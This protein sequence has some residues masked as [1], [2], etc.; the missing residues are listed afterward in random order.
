MKP[1]V[2]FTKK[3]EKLELLFRLVESGLVGKK[4]AIKIHFGEKGNVTYLSPKYVKTVF[5]RLKD[6]GYKPT[7]IES[8]VLYQGERTFAKSHIALAKSHGYNFGPIDIYD[9]RG[10]KDNWSVLIKG[11]HFKQVKLVKNLQRYDSLV[12]FSHFK[13]HVRAGFG[14]A[15]KNLGMGLASRAGKLAMHVNLAPEIDPERCIACGK[16]IRSCP[17]QAISLKGNKAFIDKK[18]CIGCAECIAK[19]PQKAPQPFAASSSILQERIVEYAAGVLKKI[20][21]VFV[22][23]VLNVTAHCD[24]HA[25]KDKILIRHIGFLS[26]LDAVAIDQAAYDLVKNRCGYNLFKKVNQVSGVRQLIYAEQ[27]GL[28]QRKYKLISLD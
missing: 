8:N 1:E 12:V 22:S 6:S 16:C 17:V 2:F 23:A 14:G 9:E 13:G 28:G 18:I 10:V 21:T 15:L 5:K 3:F 19:C 26:S 25:D 24:C 7:F 27:L 20:P 4:I 11:R